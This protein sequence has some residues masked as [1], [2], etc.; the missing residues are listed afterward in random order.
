MTTTRMIR[1]YG[2]GLLYGGLVVLVA[3]L[4]AGP[5]W[6]GQPLQVVVLMACCLALR[7]A[8]IPLSKYSYLTQTGLLALTGSLL[9][10]LPA[11]ALAVAAGTLSADWL[12]Q[13]KAVRS[14]LIN[15]GREVVALVAG[16]GTYAALV[17]ALGLAGAGLSVELLPP[18]LAYAIAYFAFSRILFHFGLTPHP[19][20]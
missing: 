9:V 7:G 5:R 2:L 3:V 15:A 12:W 19:H 16:F 20:V 11:T 1:L 10:G 18:L 6:P 13:R 8:Q 17:Q 4:A 14:A